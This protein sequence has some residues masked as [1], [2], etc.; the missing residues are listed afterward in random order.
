M[1]E[2]QSG[3]TFLRKMF[4]KTKEVVALPNLIEVQSKSFNDFVQLDYLPSERLNIGLEKVLRDIFPVEYNARIAL[5]YVS[6]E[7]G[8]WSCICGNLTGISARYQ[9][10]HHGSKKTGCSRLTDQQLASGH[11]YVRCTKCQA[12]VTLKPQASPEECRYGGKTYSVPLRVKMQLT[13]WDIDPVTNESLM[14]D[15]KEQEVFFCDLP[16]MLD[17]Y[18]DNDGRIKA[19]NQGIFLINGV[20]RVVVSQI[21]RAPGVLF[22]VNKKTKDFRGNASLLARIIPARGAWLDFEFDQNDFLHVRID[23]KKKLLVT[24]FLQ[25][26]GLKREEILPLF[27][28]FEKIEYADGEFIR[29]LNKGLVGTRLELGALSKEIEKQFTV[30]QRITEP[31]FQKLKKL[32]VDCLKIRRSSLI[33]RIVAEDFVHPKTGELLLE[34]GGTIKEGVLDYIESLNAS[35][36]LTV[37]QTSSHAPQ[38]SLA[39]TLAQDQAMTQDEAVKEV[40]SK[41]RP[42]DLPSIKVM[43]D[44][45]MDLFFN[46]RHYDLTVVG[47]TR[48]NRKLGVNLS[49]DV[50]TLALEDIVGLVRYLIGLKERGEGE[51]DDVDHLSN[52][53][54]RL[55]RELLQ[56]QFYVGLARIEKI[57]SERFRLQ[58]SYAAQMPSDFINV[59]PLS[60]VL[61]EFFGTGQLS[62]FMDQTNPLAEMAHKRRLSALGPG[63]ITRDRAT[64]DVRDVHP[65]HYGRICPIETPEG[66][67]IGLISSLSTYARVNE[68]G[69]IEAVYRPVEDGK[70]TDKVVFIDAYQEV[71]KAVAQATVSM[72]KAGAIT[73]SY[74]LARRD[75]A[76]QSMPVEEIS[77]ID[78]SPR[79]LVS[80]ATALI[81]FLEHDD[82]NR[83]LMGSNMQRQAVPLVKPEVP[84]VGTGVEWE[85]GRAEGAVIIA[86]SSGIVKYVSADKIIIALE[87]DQKSDEEWFARPIDVYRLK[88]FGRSSHNTWV[89]YVPAVQAGKFVQRG[90]VLAHGA[91][92]SEG[93]LSLGSN[94]LV[95]YMPWYGYNFEDAI[96]VSRRCVADDVFTSV[97]VEE[98]AVEARDTKLGAEEITR[99][100][101]NVSEK[102]LE[103]LDED[104]IVK[105]GTRV[106]PGDI[107]VGKVTF[108]GDVQVSPEEKLLRALFGEKSREVK[109]TSSRVPPGV[110]GT[111]VDVKILSR[112]GIRKDKRYKDVVQKETLEIEE[113]YAWQVGVLE[114]SIKEKIIAELQGLSLKGSDFATASV[115]ELLKTKVTDKNI[116]TKL[117]YYRD[118]L[119]SQEKVLEALKAEQVSKLRKGDDLP[120]GVIK[121]VRVYVA[122]KRPVSVGDKMAG[123]HGNKGV[124]SAIVNV[125]DMP[126]LADGT[127]VDIVLNPLGVPGRMNV[128]QIL[129]TMLGMGCHK[130]GE[131]LADQINSMSFKQ[132][133]SFMKKYYAPELIKNIQEKY[134][135]EGV[136]D[137]ARRT[138]AL[139]LRISTP[140]FDGASFEDDISPLLDELGLPNRGVYTL[141]D[142]QTGEAFEQ[143]V[144]VGY[145]YMMKL[146]HLADDKLHARSVGPCSLITQQPLGGKAQFGG[147]RLGEMEVW[148]LFA[149]GS[150]HILQEMLTIKSD[151]VNGRLKAYEAIVRGDEL[152]EP[153][154]PESFNVLVKELQS[155]GLQVELFRTGREQASE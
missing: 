2:V 10:K 21:H 143:P 90:Q 106:E 137:A 48:I 8:D 19:G 101:P 56:S 26:L 50:T 70:V 12:R 119:D 108:K 15:I 152:P 1:S 132:V 92:I 110:A 118:I 136:M 142:G 49:L 89:H 98:F 3:V 122:V 75:G 71:G 41:L 87:Q 65:S 126:Y 138:A 52:R 78:A 133:E 32:S 34:R 85:V 86:R 58:E 116:A 130:V 42:G 73:D 16:I 88:K 17:L 94:V 22:A 37:I 51:L 13:T 20:D 40:Y 68:L 30:G 148:A 141:Y 155:L 117:A 45:V 14:R 18:E 44:Y 134:G 84:L 121:L 11:S 127:S 124:V 63:G 91:S 29:P 62:Q 113:N 7:L 77:Y 146:N 131:R 79:Q 46:G 112:S 115:H 61:R 33:N 31:V 102:E 135:D 95:A 104:G 93:E 35:C 60:A 27:Y 28:S 24:T 47:R 100:I 43:T 74:V 114:R 64:L 81:P 139:G 53:C 6:Y 5:E 96:V 150:A 151:D 59:K 105:I 153:G 129:E 76:M 145:A 103:P 9:W 67:N 36:S 39:L 149:Y 97:Y 57:I 54:V 69:F 38:L 82:A 128:G 80:V 66:Q 154:I 107:L 25:A 120:S 144:T 147:Q 83:A 23:K 4:G 99:D 111:V 72:D 55:V 109:D 140:V 123:R 125:E